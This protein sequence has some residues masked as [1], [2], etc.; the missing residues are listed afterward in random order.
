MSICFEGPLCKNEINRWEIEDCELTSGMTAKLLIGGYWVQGR[1][2]FIGSDYGFIL[3]DGLVFR[4]R[5]G[6]RAKVEYY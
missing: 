6:M 5:T 3:D 2:E 4:P 1:C